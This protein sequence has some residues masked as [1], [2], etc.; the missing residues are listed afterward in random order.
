MPVKPVC[1][2]ATPVNPE[3]LQEFIDNDSYWFEPK[4]DGAR[5]MIQP[6][7]DGWLTYLSRKG[8]E[9]IP[10][11]K[12]A[13]TMVYAPFT[14]DGELVGDTFCLFDAQ[15]PGNLAHRREQ[16]ES[17][18]KDYGPRFVKLVPVARTADEKTRLV[19]AVKK[20]DGEGIVIKDSQAPYRNGRSNA[21]L[22]L[23]FY[24][25]V[26]VIVTE[27]NRKGKDEAI[28][29]GW[30]DGTE[31]GGCKVIL[32]KISDLNVDDVVEIRCLSVSDTGKLIQPVFIRKRTDKSPHECTRES[33]E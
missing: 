6:D 32:S 22:K 19:A 11:K 15:I 2:L 5:M 24:R 28:S 14:L 7:E 1:Q 33:Q 17:Y 29:I 4:L 8:D 21:W 13:E 18:Y 26:D 10:P 9:I 31:A 30:A 12:L 20:I 25:T 27:I 16:I 3:Q 23:K